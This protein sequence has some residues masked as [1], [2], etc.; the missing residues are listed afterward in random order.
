MRRPADEEIPVAVIMPKALASRITLV[1]PAFVQVL[2][3][4]TSYAEKVVWKVW[5]WLLKD[6]HPIALFQDSKNRLQTLR[7]R[8]Q[9]IPIVYKL[10]LLV[11]VLIVVCMGLLGTI[12][13]Q[14]QTQLFQNQISEQGSTLARLMAEAAKEPLLAEDQ[15]ALDAIVTSFS[16]SESVLGTDILSLEGKVLTRDGNMQT[17]S[18][19]MNKRL[20][21]GINTSPDDSQATRVQYTANDQPSN[22]ITFIQ[23]IE[24]QE[25]TIGYAVVSFSKV[26]MELSMRQAIGTIIGATFMIILLG[27]GMSFVLGRRITGPID[28]LVDASRALSKGEYNF[29]FK[30]RRH[31][32]LGLL[33]TAFNEMAEGMLEKSQVKD[34]LSRYVSP[35]V[36]NKILSNLDTVELDSKQVEGTVLFADIISF[37]Q[38][39]ENTRPE[40]LITLL[41]QYFSL[42]TGACEENHGIVDKYMG[43]GVMLVFGVPEADELHGFHAISCALLIQKLITYENERRLRNGDPAIQ[44][45]IGLN[46]G[47]M[48]AGNMGSKK[49]MDYTVVG[50][51]V[52]LASRLCGIGNGGQ[53]VISRNLY[54]LPDVCE[55][56]LAGEY[57]SIRLR[58]IKNPVN[59]YIVESLKA[60]WEEDI[61]RQF[62][63]VVNALYIDKADA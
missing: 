51:T 3:R 10:S 13:I 29:K 2:L 4:L 63:R 59:T 38:L 15:L 11:T 46:A 45:R 18:T 21:D 16:N 7:S 1:K 41:N 32:E 44:F 54:S 36:A 49:R 26:G 5:P 42:I 48:L 39:A 17:S 30:E 19:A 62:A 9:Y 57:Q 28:E 12:L 23:P 61:E 8:I 22:V 37:T 6:I 58:G 55:R 43:D 50:D 24:F 33:M 52:N 34:A 60:E 35:V 27:I 40:D 20:I 14:Q 56:V 53:V 25:I 47:S 31:D